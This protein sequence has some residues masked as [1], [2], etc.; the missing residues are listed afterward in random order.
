M[1]NSGKV[2]SLAGVNKQTLRYYERIGLID[3]A[4]RDDSGYR[5]Y[6]AETVDRIRF[7]QRAKDLGFQLAEIS[8][9]LKLRID[10]RTNCDRVRSRAAAKRGEVQRKLRDLRRL[11]RALAGLI[12]ACDQRV[13]TDACPILAALE[14]EQT[15]RRTGHAG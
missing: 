10:R 11:D 7:I 14:S 13:T 15:R 5:K 3:P 8:E 1:L 2:A 6:P 9:L 4:P 12:D